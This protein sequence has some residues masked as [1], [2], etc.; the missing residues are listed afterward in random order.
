[1]SVNK[2]H[3]HNTPTARK[4][5]SHYERLTGH[6]FPLGKYN[7]KLNQLDGRMGSWVWELATISGPERPIDFG[8]VVPA[9]KCV[10][11]PKHIEVYK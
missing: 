7:A 2:G 1:M 6:A 4:L 11:N 5:V 3:K 8:S 10:L 9:S